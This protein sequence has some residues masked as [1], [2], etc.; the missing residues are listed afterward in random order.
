MINV[1]FYVTLSLKSWGYI[2]TG[3]P[4]RK[5]GVG[6]PGGGGGDIYPHY[7]SAWNL[8]KRQIKIW[9]LFTTRCTYNTYNKTS[10]IFCLFAISSNVDV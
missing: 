6:G 8:F 1:K 9:Q 3:H 7:G 5:V 2:G 10:R 4:L